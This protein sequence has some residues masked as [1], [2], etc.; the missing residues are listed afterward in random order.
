MAC[1][2]I[3]NGR[4]LECK[5]FTAGVVDAYIAKYQ[6]INPTIVADEMTGLGTLTE[7]FRFELKNTGNVPTETLTSSRENGTTFYDISVELVMT[8]LS[9][10]LI[11]QAKL[12]TR[13]RFL[14]FIEDNNG[15]IH[16]FGL[17]NGMDKT[18]GVREIAGDLGGFYGL[19]M[20]I[21][22]QE[23]QPAPILSTLAAT[24]LK[25]LVSANY[26]ND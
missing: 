2:F 16:C 15:L 23:P 17:K 1:E 3:T 14:L 4:I 12:L 21:T 10:P 13:D 8:G 22:G 9:A 24:S 7:V 11:N 25:A 6:K 20:T 18:A 5:N 19:K 26:V